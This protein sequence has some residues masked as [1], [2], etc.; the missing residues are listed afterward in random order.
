MQASALNSLELNRRRS[1]PALRGLV[2]VAAAV[3]VLV[4]SARLSFPHP[5]SA[6]P[7]PVTCQVLAVLALGL[8]LPRRQAVAAVVSYLALGLA[9]APVFA[10]GTGG[11]A[12]LLGPTAGY[13]LGFLPAAWL[14]GGAGSGDGVL[15]LALRALGGLALIHL[16][17]FSW[18]ALL[19]G[20]AVAAFQGGVLPF[21]APDL[22]KLVAAVAAAVVF[23]RR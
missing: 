12:V 5:F 1:H 19:T 3:A 18:L 13:L 8:S 22:L 6:T 2:R 16:A 7:V 11:A 21:A 17:G 15:K 20:D 10:W 14:T 4:L 23:R 9:G